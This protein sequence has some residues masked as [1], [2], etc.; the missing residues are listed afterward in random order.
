MPQERNESLIYRTFCFAV[1]VFLRSPVASLPRL[2]SLIGL[3]LCGMVLAACTPQAPGG[4]ELLRVSDETS[5]SVIDNAPW[6]HFLQTYVTVRKHN[7]N[8]V[9]YADVTPEDKA[10]LDAYVSYLQTV[11]ITT[12][13]RDEQ[14][15]F[16]MNLYNAATVKTVLEHWPVQ[17]ILDIHISPGRKNYGP[18]GLK[19]LMVEGHSLALEN[20]EHHILREMFADADPKVHYGLN[21]ASMGCP[22]LIPHAITGANWRTL[23][24]EN[25]RDFVNSPH[26]VDFPR[27]GMMAVSKIYHSWFQS[28]FGGNEESVVEH[29]LKYA[30]PKKAKEIKRCAGISS[31]FYDW[32]LNSP[33]MLTKEGR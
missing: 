31:D 4:M 10:A 13:N 19:M 23:L 17:S 28:D 33:S 7:S 29:L 30:E 2:R 22:S 9:R 14:L 11:P 6:E 32:R 8:L 20:I 26:G 16:W 25:A 27:P 12:M 3:L 21:C 18:W 24:T 5:T 1:P 15:A